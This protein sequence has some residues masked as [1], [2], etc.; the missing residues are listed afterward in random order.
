[1]KTLACTPA[2]GRTEELKE[3]QLRTDPKAVTSKGELPA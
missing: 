3:V 1:M 2:L